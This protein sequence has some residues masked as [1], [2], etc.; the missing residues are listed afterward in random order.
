[1][2]GFGRFLLQMRNIE[3]NPL[4]RY[5]CNA[6]FMQWWIYLWE[7]EGGTGGIYEFKPAVV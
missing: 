4:K 2:I 5:F 1:M 6:S 7:G 3:K